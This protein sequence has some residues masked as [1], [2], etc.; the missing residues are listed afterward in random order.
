MPSLSKLH[1]KCEK[2][3]NIDNCDSKRLVACELM[4]L[5]KEILA[6]INNIV[7]ATIPNLC[8]MLTPM[9]KPYTPVTIHMGEYGDIHTSMEEIKENL[10]KEINKSFQIN[11]TLNKS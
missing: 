8:N 9:A 1:E 2:C 4:E 10:S 3:S 6:P 5:P 11:C 7:N